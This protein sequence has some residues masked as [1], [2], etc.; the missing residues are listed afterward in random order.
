M[1]VTPRGFVVDTDGSVL[2]GYANPISDGRGIV[3]LSADFKTCTVITGSGSSGGKIDKGQGTALGGF[4]QGFALKDGKIF[5]LTT[6]PKAL[7]QIE[8]VTGDRTMVV[9]GGTGT[10]LGERHVVWDA[11][12]KLWWIAGIQSS[13]T[14]YAY[15]PATSKLTMAQKDC[16]DTSFIKHCWAGPINI[17]TLNYGGMIVHPTTGRMY[18]G[19]DTM[20]IVEV[21]PET[22]NSLILSL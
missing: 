22:G 14:V 3:R 18:F 20:A 19:H 13:V 17:N 2:L 16:G 12:R 21:E 8:P 15:D 10:S 6:Q 4:V 11:K 9:G 1:Q 5:A 7:W